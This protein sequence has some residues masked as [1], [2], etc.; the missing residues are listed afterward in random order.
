LAAA[1]L[2]TWCSA[3]KAMQSLAVFLRY[4]LLPA[5]LLR[6]SHLRMQSMVVAPVLFGLMLISAVCSTC[7]AGSIASFAQVSPL[8]AALFAPTQVS[9]EHDSH[10]A[11]PAIL[12]CLLNRP[13]AALA[14]VW[15]AASPEQAL[16]SG[17][18]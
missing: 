16:H 8:A 7:C 15:L 1:L 2:R 17:Q 12:F 18:H 14:A 9:L 10:T 6:T 5:L 11:V 4:A 13:A 3:D